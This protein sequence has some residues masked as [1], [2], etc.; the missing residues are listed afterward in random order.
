MKHPD[1]PMMSLGTR[2]HR[3]IVSIDAPNGL[4][5]PNSVVYA[6][7]LQFD[8]HFPHPDVLAARKV[9]EERAT[10]RAREEGLPVPEVWIWRPPQRRRAS[11]ASLHGARVVLHVPPALAEYVRELAASSGCEVTEA[12]R[13]L[14]ARARQEGLQIVDRVICAEC[15]GCWHR[16]EIRKGRCPN[17]EC[18]APFV[19]TAPVRILPGETQTDPLASL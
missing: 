9:L 3:V 14:V 4:L 5:I 15:L 6:E 12:Y 2:G 11:S 7:R 13:R 16:T 18:D 10:L 17:R 19:L 1:L 8:L